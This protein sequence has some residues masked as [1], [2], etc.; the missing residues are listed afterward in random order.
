[1][2]PVRV[3]KSRSLQYYTTQATRHLFLTFNLFIVILQYVLSQHNNI[4]NVL[5]QHVSTRESHR[6]ADYLRTVNILYP[7]Q[8]CVCICIL[9]VCFVS[10][11][12]AAQRGPWPPHSRG[13]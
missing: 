3:I 4:I 7:L 2:C 13:F 12:A 9:F 11:G 10:C 5:L 6:Q 1:M 8:Y